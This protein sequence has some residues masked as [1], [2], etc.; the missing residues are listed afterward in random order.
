MVL[1]L[2]TVRSRFIQTIHS[3]SLKRP[4]S[5]SRLDFRSSIRASVDR[6][7]DDTK[8]EMQHYAT[9]RRSLRFWAE[10]FMEDRSCDELADPFPKKTVMRPFDT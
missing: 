9:P 8:V 7:C 2:K 5:D 1:V 3:R 10:S 6:T 4:L